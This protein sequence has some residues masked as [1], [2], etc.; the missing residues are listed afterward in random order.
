MWVAH[1]VVDSVGIA[2]NHMHRAGVYPNEAWGRARDLTT[3]P[4]PQGNGRYSQDI[5]YHLLN[6][7]IRLPPSAGSASGVLPNPV[8]YNRVYVHVDGEF[9]YPKWKQGLK[10]G[11]SFVSNGPL[12]RVRAN[13]QWPGVVLRTNGSLTVR[14]EGQLDSLDPIAAVE[15]V[16]NGKVQPV[17]LPATFTL[18][19]SGWFLVRAIADVPNTFRFASTA[20]WYVELDGKPAPPRADSV[21]YFITWCRER[22]STLQDLTALSEAQKKQVL[23][24]WKDAEKFWLDRLAAR[25]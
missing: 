22:I 16:Q 8:G 14:L 24:P 1:G 5:Y 23:E 6:S 7:G 21:Q 20:P 4:G 13:G 2:N 12:L 17:K 18:G 25:P 11:R 19:E 9:T 15:L 3:Y 10:A